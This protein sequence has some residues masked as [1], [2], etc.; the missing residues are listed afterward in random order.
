MYKYNYEGRINVLPNF[1][2]PNFAYINDIHKYINV[3]ESDFCLVIAWLL[4]VLYPNSN[5]DA[6]VLWIEGECNI[7]KTIASKIL[8]RLVD[9]CTARMLL[10]YAGR[11]DF[12]S[13]LNVQYVSVMDNVLAIT[14]KL[15]D[16][17]C[18]AATGEK[19]IIVLTKEGVLYAMQHSNIIVNSF[20][21][22]SKTFELRERCFTVRIR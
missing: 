6:L 7:G 9:L 15:K 4:I 16:V 12:L 20:R 3:G 21:S 5:V 8:K 19:I 17:L 13:I 10:R 22:V 2:S 18:R 11:N 1:V 14:L